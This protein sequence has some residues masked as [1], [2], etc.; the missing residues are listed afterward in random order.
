MT[1]LKRSR[2]RGNHLDLDYRDPH[3][4]IGVPVSVF[5]IPGVDRRVLARYWFR[6]GVTVQCAVIVYLDDGPQMRIVPLNQV[7]VTYLDPPPMPKWA[8]G[9][10]N[11]PVVRF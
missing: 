10:E 8:Q 11:S 4:Q 1:S 7:T 2:S 9:A 3:L 5:G 6:V